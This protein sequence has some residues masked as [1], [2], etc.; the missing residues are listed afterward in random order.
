[1]RRLLLLLLFALA[2]CTPV[3]GD[4]DDSTDE[5]ITAEPPCTRWLGAEPQSYVLDPTLVEISGL[6]ASRQTPGALWVHEDSGAGPE[7]HA[8]SPDGRTV[9]IVTLQGGPADDWEDLALGACVGAP[10]PTDGGPWCLVVGDIGDNPRSRPFVSLLTIEEPAVDLGAESAER[11]DLTPT[12]VT[13]T[14]PGGPRDA[15]ALVIEPDGTPVVIS[16]RTDGFA[17]LYRMP[18][19][20]SGQPTEAL[21]IG[22]TLIGPVGGLVDAVTAADLSIDGSRLLIRTYADGLLYDLG[23]GGLPGIDPAM[24]WSLPVAAEPQGEAIAW[25]DD[26]RDIL[27]VSEAVEPPLNRLVCR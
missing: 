11:I 26:E 12:V 9:A 7:L 23:A 13:A 27:H 8:L 25:T 22:E 19:E 14:Y 17:R 21:Q 1:M 2:A 20:P 3:T 5:P 15:E 10:A 24:Q 6:V 4:D 16:K 18:T